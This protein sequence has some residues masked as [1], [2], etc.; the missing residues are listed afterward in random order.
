MKTFLERYVAGEYEQVWDESLQRASR[1]DFGD[2]L[3]PLRWP[4]EALVA[5]DYLHKYYISGAGSL[6][7]EIPALAADVPLMFEG[8][9]IEV[10]DRDLTF[11]RYLRYAMQSGG[12]LA[13]TPLS[14]WEA[15][16]QDDLAYLTKDL[17]PI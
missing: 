7:I 4:G 17:F 1:R 13:F 15:R 12:F 8:G 3:V 9:P 6:Y 2:A 16:P 14:V 10:E 5:P 11:V